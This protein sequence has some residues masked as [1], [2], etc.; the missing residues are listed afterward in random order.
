MNTKL[1]FEN[2]GESCGISSCHWAR[3]R[4]VLLPVEYMC[5]SVHVMFVDK[6]YDIGHIC[7]S[8][9]CICNFPFHFPSISPYPAVLSAHQFFYVSIVDD[10]KDTTIIRVMVQAVSS[11]PVNTRAWIQSR[12]IPCK[13]VG[14]SATGL[15]RPSISIFPCQ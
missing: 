6:I 9:S 14:R 7:A 4:E 8:P 1:I 13:T 11:G 10:G 12:A 3:N 15:C 5:F 2:G